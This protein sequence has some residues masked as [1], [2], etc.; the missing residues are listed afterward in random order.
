MNQEARLLNELT[1]QGE[2]SDT[3]LRSLLERGSRE[4]Q[5]SVVQGKR[6][7]QAAVG[8]IPSS[9]VGPFLVALSGQGIVMIH[10]LRTAADPEH[11][12]RI[13]RRSFDPVADQDAAEIVGEELKRFVAGDESA[14][15]SAIDLSLVQSSFHRRI[16]ELLLQVG[17]GAILSYSSLASWGRAPHA[18]RA[19]GGAMHD[20]PIPVYVP[21]HRV[22]RSDLSL[23]GYGGGLDVKYKLLCAEGFSFTAAGAVAQFGAV[24]GN[25]GTQIYC[26]PDCRA[27]ARADRTNIILFRDAARAEQSAMRPCRIC[28]QVPARSG[29]VAKNGI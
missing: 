28:M 17:P 24:W 15:R 23:G 13:L 18:S 8:V 29:R 6:R 7:P 19:V 21:C 14:L 20:N 26:R 16:L 3:V 4:R 10:F 11:A 25:R 1:R 12:I 27:L 22:V 9:A 5:F 2:D